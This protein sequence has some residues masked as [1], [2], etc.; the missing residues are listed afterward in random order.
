MTTI[1]KTCDQ[2]G[3]KINKDN[4]CRSFSY[5]LSGVNIGD[6]PEGTFTNGGEFCGALCARDFLNEACE[7][8]TEPATT[9][10]GI[11]A[12]DKAE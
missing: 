8:A 12:I 2:C 4:G 11:A 1:T 6:A 10:T 5:V 3:R 9:P 7:P